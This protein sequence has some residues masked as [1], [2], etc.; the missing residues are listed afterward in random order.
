M[1]SRESFFNK[2]IYINT[3]RRFRLG[4]A[5]YFLLLFLC[6][7]LP[8][9]TRGVKDLT[10]SYFQFGRLAFANENSLLFDGSFLYLPLLISLAVP[11]VVA[12][13]VYNSLHSPRHAIFVH[14]LPISRRANFISSALAA[15]TLM[16]APIALT[17]AVLLGMS[18]CGYA[19]VIGVFPILVWVL[20][21]FFIT[22]VMFA[23]AGF[24]AVISANSFAVVG[25]NALL[26][27]LPVA[28]AWG[29]QLFAGQFL[30]GYYDNGG[31][32]EK[33]IR[34]SLPVWIFSYGEGKHI[35]NMFSGAGAWMFIAAAAVLFVISILLYKKRKIELCGDVA[36]YAPVRIVLKYTVCAISFVICFGIFYCGLSM[37]VW[38]FAL[39]S[40]VIC[41][42][43]YFASEM[44]L[45]KN[46]RVFGKWKGLCG[47]GAACVLSM[48]FI[49]YTGFFGYETR[50]PD[51]ADIGE[52]V[53]YDYFNAEIPYMDNAKFIDEVIDFHNSRI[54]N[55]VSSQ[56][57][58]D[59]M[60]KED[61]EKNN[62]YI[63][64]VSYKLKNGKEITRQYYVNNNDYDAIMSRLFEFAGY[65][66]KLTGYNTLIPENIKS[67]PTT[68]FAGNYS[69]NCV[70]NE[71]VGEFMEA[72]KKDIDQISYK[73][74]K[75]SFYP[76]WN[77]QIEDD[78]TH[79]KKGELP[80]FREDPSDDDYRGFYKYFSI[81]VTSNYKNS[82][83]FLKK[84]GI[85]E[86]TLNNMAER[87][88]ITPQPLVKKGNTVSYE[89]IKRNAKTE[90]EGDI[91]LARKYLAKLD[92]KEA[93]DFAETG[94]KMEDF[95]T[96][97]EG[98]YYLIFV[99][100]ANDVYASSAVGIIK[101]E[102]LPD[103][104]K[105]YVKQ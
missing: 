29:M 71:N 4:S 21:H 16:W 13:L 99:T 103:A 98:E 20:V 83:D 70:I 27:A 22:G 75:E 32:T 39:I 6:V 33:L 36:A 104:L 9:L 105:K 74:Y 53:I 24:A 55:I 46:M 42:V 43:V 97:P 66:E 72:L 61:S 18:L 96:L 68:V 47:F 69:F 87:T 56:R 84:H 50:V 15:L 101:K 37:K 10:N 23:T 57:K 19:R 30:F 63:V 25:I 11:T 38:A 40:A 60:F 3:L 89:K 48:L 85:Y 91:C 51:K 90:E 80:L 31:I 28:I 41:S 100:E 2:G 64:N 93:Y 94:I 82:M 62:Y 81:S 92:A 54:A 86:D 76:S 102:E 88:Y 59:K 17:G 78:I 77:V 26:L 8:L 95:Y 65:K 52:A 67:V 7:P 49:V 45:Q 44:L 35:Y 73:E 1:T 12:L 34:F 14:S 58:I 79:R 5:L